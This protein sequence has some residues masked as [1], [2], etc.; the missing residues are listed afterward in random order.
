MCNPSTLPLFYFCLCCAVAAAA[1]VHTPPGQWPGLLLLFCLGSQAKVVIAW[2]PGWAVQVL[3][4]RGLLLLLVLG[5]SR[6]NVFSQVLIIRLIFFENNYI[7]DTQWIA[8][9]V[10]MMAAGKIFLFYFIFPSRFPVFLGSCLFNY[11]YTGC[12]F[13]K[14]K[15]GTNTNKR[16]N[17]RHHWYIQAAILNNQDASSSYFLSLDSHSKSE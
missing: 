16:R 3:C 15:Q 4:V 14:R 11:H 8:S 13:E 10:L 5:G 6:S 1:A 9:E 17:K 12:P 7:L 2:G